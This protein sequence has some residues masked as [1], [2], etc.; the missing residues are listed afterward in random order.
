MS[1]MFPLLA[2]NDLRDG[3]LR[4]AESLA[5][6]S[7]RWPAGA[8]PYNQYLS[9]LSLGNFAVNVVF[10]VRAIISALGNAIE[11][12]IQILSKPQMRWVAA[13]GIVASVEHIDSIWNGTI[14]KR[15]S[16]SVSLPY[17]FAVPC[18]AISAAIF[19]LGPNPTRIGAVRLVHLGPKLIYSWWSDRCISMVTETAIMFIAQAKRL[20]LSSAPTD[21]AN[22]HG[23]EFTSSGN[24]VQR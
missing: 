9:G 1:Q 22:S 18:R 24:R 3:R 23:R 16:Q 11:D 20:V 15:P 8:L 5:Y 6:L 12:V 17:S 10:A 14:S 21:F 7:L 4:Y 2:P 19:G 13:R